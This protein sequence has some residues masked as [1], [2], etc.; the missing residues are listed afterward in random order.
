MGKK[1]MLFIESGGICG[2]RDDPCNESDV[3]LF[4]ILYKFP[5][6]KDITIRHTINFMHSE[7]NIPYGIIKLFF[8]F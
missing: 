2:S 4:C 5:Y 3:K 1:I 7:K 6:F 8:H